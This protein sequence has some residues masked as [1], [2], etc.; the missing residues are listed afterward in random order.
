[1]RMTS[2]SRAPEALDARS[3]GFDVERDLDLPAF[4]AA[5]RPQAARLEEAEHLI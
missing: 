4:P 1:M 2:W 5:G 3:G